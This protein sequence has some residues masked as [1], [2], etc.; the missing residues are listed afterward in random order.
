M[1]VFFRRNG[2]GHDIQGKQ[3]VSGK[4]RWVL[5][6]YSNFCSFFTFQRVIDETDPAISDNPDQVEVSNECNSVMN[7]RS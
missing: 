5:G 7:Y 4:K 6:A 3:R 2:T 1:R